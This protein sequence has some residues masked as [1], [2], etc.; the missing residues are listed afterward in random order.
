MRVPPEEH[1]LCLYISVFVWIKQRS[2]IMLTTL[3]GRSENA[4][5]R[6]GMSFLTMFM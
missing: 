4:D 2:R 6:Q 5:L 3:E 1:E